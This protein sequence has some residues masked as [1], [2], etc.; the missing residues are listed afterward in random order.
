MIINH[1]G[2]KDWTAPTPEVECDARNIAKDIVAYTKDGKT[3]GTAPIDTNHRNVIYECGS[4]KGQLPT[5]CTDMCYGAGK[6]VAVFGTTV[7][8]YS[9]DGIVWDKVTNARSVNRVCYGDEGFIAYYY[10]SGSFGSG[11]RYFSSDG[12]KW[13]VLSDAVAYTMCY[14][15][16]VY[17]ELQSNGSVYST[18][19]NGST[20]TAM[21]SL[22][23]S[24]SW[25]NICYGGING[26][27]FVAEGYT[28]SSSGNV[29]T[30]LAY[31]K[32]KGETW[33]SISSILADIRSIC[34]GNGRFVMAF[35]S[36]SSG[37]EVKIVRYSTN[38]MSWG[39]VT[40]LPVTA[41][42][43]KVFYISGWFYLCSTTGDILRSRD[44][45]T[46]EEYTNPLG[47]Q[48]TQMADGIDRRIMMADNKY[49]LSTIMDD[50][51]T[52]VQYELQVPTEGYLT[53]KYDDKEV[54]LQNVIGEKQ[55]GD[56]YPQDNPSTETV[57]YWYD[58]VEYAGGKFFIVPISKDT[59]HETTDDAWTSYATSTIGAYSL[60]GIIW[61][62]VTFPAF[63]YGYVSYGNDIY[64]SIGTY[65][66]KTITDT[67][68]DDWYDLVSTSKA[69]YSTTGLGWTSVSLP[70][71]QEWK[72]L[73]YG[74]GMFVAVGNA[75]TTFYKD[76]NTGWDDAMCTAISYT[77]KA[78][79]KVPKSNIVLSFTYLCYGNGKFVA[80]NDEDRKLYYSN[81]GTEW[82]PIS[83][84]VISLN[85]R[86]INSLI[87]GNDLFVISVNNY[88]YYSKNLYDWDSTYVGSSYIYYGNGKFHMGSKYSYDCKTWYDYPYNISSGV[89]G[90]DRWIS[91]STTWTDKIEYINH[92]LEDEDIIKKGEISTYG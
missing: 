42:W 75:N 91:G 48:I 76:D 62:K 55:R 17:L 51:N 41:L 9:K 61:R 5:G 13:N 1:M 56:S 77:G 54:S 81:D 26:G 85:I 36:S 89:Y 57:T 4:E 7:I 43:E 10:S 27:V 8:A 88:V 30:Y 11:Y 24:Y 71:A 34:Y 63:C 28:V 78:W 23:S 64:V 70:I 73:C 50:F 22:S 15:N 2:K 21:T 72:G 3:I 79:T 80:I 29:T 87:F 20:R 44:G 86:S 39:S 67:H 32:N 31:S 52:P 83:C 14:G 25:E 40:N 35:Y 68:T 49:V 69:A 59:W 47:S 45:A 92:T 37:S 18:T 38:G 6:F 66:L 33:S 53:L 19:N 82:H 74:N 16:D 46:W 84:P 12:E 90:N 58:N 65:Q 60:D